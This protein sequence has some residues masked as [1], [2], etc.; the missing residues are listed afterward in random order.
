M[1]QCTN[2]AAPVLGKSLVESLGQ[3]RYSIAKGVRYYLAF[4]PSLWLLII[5]KQTNKQ[6]NKQTSMSNAHSSRLSV[7]KLNGSLENKSL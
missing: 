3:G 5:K 6:T 2:N 1:H 7:L 4:K